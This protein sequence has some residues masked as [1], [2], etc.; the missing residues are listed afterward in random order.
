VE[1]NKALSRMKEAGWG[2]QKC[3]DD[4]GK[5]AEKQRGDV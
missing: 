2:G 3:E 1:G 4:R 5:K